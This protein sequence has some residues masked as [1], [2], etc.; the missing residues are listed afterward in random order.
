MQWCAVA[1]QIRP[2]VPKLAA[3]MDEAG[4]D[5]LAYMSFPKEHRAKL[6]SNN[7]IERFNGEIKRRTK[8]SASSQTRTPSPGSSA[9]SCSQNVMHCPCPTLAALIGEFCRILLRWLAQATGE[10]CSFHPPWKDQPVIKKPRHKGRGKFGLHHAGAQ[11]GHRTGKVK[12]WRLELSLMAKGKLSN[13][14]LK[15]EVLRPHPGR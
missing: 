10:G 14:A 7:P 3:I 5:V 13:P 12:G 15:A 8:S 6:L 1:D 11:P 4:H 9:Q 2:L